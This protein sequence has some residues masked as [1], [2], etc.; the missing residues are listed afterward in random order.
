MLTFIATGMKANGWGAETP[1]PRGP[2][3][4]HDVLLIVS[5]VLKELFTKS[6]CRTLVSFFFHPTD[7][8]V[9]F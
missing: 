3:T 7:R 5:S 1:D 4:P 9:K 2:A 6:M 8:P